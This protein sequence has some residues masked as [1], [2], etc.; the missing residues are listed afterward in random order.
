MKQEG[1]EAFILGCT[2]LSAALRDGDYGFK[3]IDTLEVLAKSAIVQSGYKLKI[4]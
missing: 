2:E 1:A 4:S 3:F